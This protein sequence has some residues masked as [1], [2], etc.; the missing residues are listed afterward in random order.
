MSE[1]ILLDSRN[2]IA[3][4]TLNRPERGNTL[5][6]EL[7]V[8]F[9]NAINAIANDPSVRAV[10]LTGAGRIF[11]AGGDITSFVSAGE[12]LA[13]MIDDLL[14]ILNGAMLKLATLPVPVVS[15]LNGPVGGGGIGLA[16][17]A[18][19]VLAGNS[20]K[21]RGGYA[22]IGLTPDVGASWFLTRRVG[23]SRAK[24]VFFLNRP[25]L[26]RECLAWGIVDCV[27][28]D[29]QLM[30][31]A[32]KLVVQLA[33]GPARVLGRIKKLVDG[34]LDLGLAEH[35]GL[36][37]EY[38]V[39]SGRSDDAREGVHAFVEKRAPNFDRG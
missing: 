29:E 25:L 38:M 13:Q 8:A 12:N 19:M 5:D 30:E 26:A 9:N 31:E 28:Q 10:L 32:E 6:L 23:P 24:Q 1:P 34:A 27:Y 4:I 11:C 22:A 39:A 36:E 14:G 16:L 7:A 17:C 3:R 35:L 37:R 2:G 20:V 33:Q 21:L 15:A 18:D